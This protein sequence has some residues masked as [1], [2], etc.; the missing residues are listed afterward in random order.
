MKKLSLLML[1]LLMVM[2][3]C[4]TK[5]DENSRN[6][7]YDAIVEKSAELEET[8]KEGSPDM[9]IARELTD[10]Q[11]AFVEKYPKDSLL[12]ALLMMN[13]LNYLNY[14]GEKGKGIE[15]LVDL[16]D[17]YPKSPQAISALFTVA[18]K[19]Q[20][21]QDFDNARKYYEIIIKEYPDDYLA[22]QAK[23]LLDD[24]ELTPEEFLNKRR[25]ALD[26]LEN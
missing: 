18:L 4:K 9:K 22:E 16:Y 12:P 20:D 8:I 24:I 7:D 3:S 17:K 14:L 26:S 23:I 1:M 10:L 11:E 5:I 6:A 13:A 25:E 19:Y 21:E 2:F 15:L